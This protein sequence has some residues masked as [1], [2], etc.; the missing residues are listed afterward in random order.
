MEEALGDGPVLTLLALSDSGGLHILARARPR[1][2]TGRAGP[3][4]AGTLLT[5]PSAARRGQQG[6]RGRRGLSADRPT[7]SL[8]QA[9]W[10]SKAPISWPPP[11]PSPQA[12][13]GSDV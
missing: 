10:P 11:V 12:G 6:R 2:L 13:E 7:P 1:V 8:R 3:G 9:A 5:G 4:R